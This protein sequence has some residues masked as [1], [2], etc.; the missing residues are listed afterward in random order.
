MGYLKM[1]VSSIWAGIAIS[2]GAIAYLATK[3]AIFFPI[4]LFIVIIFNLYLYTGRVPYISGIS[5]FLKLFVM[6]LGNM[7]G[8][9]LIGFI[10]RYCKP[11]MIDTAMAICQS[12][13]SEGWTLI[14]L[15]MLCNVL[16]FL[17]VHIC[18]YEEVFPIIKVICV[19]MATTT[20]VICGFEHC[21][22]NTFYFALAGNYSPLVLLYILSN[23]LCNGI[24]GVIAY[25][26]LKYISE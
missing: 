3:N 4:G 18:K 20:F 23:A 5:D 14:P 8:S 26:S 2:I 7:L 1:F 10:I 16:I 11:S 9:F 19:W 6:L 24:G 13:L 22:A 17:A 15:A 12:K 21:V 25:R